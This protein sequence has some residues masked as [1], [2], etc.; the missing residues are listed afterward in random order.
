MK[1]D[2]PGDQAIQKLLRGK[3][4]S[5]A[6]SWL[7]NSEQ[8]NVGELEHGESI[9]LIQALYELGAVKVLAVEIDASGP[10]ESTDTL[11]VTLPDDDAR[12]A[13]FAK[14]NALE[15][16]MG[17]DPEEDRGQPHLMVYFD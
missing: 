7:Q 14:V 17:F 13:I 11:I 6:L 4:R 15:R 5:E 10:Y 12:S 3:N 8:R 9:E 2:D 1:H 16:T